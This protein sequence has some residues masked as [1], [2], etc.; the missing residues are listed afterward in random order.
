MREL[1]PNL[2]NFLI[3]GSG[4]VLSLAAGAL[5]I[6]L[7]AEL[8]LGGWLLGLVDQSQIFQRILAL[9]LIAG[10]MLALGGFLIGGGGGWVLAG[11]LGTEKRLRLLVGS[12]LTF[13]LSVSLL[14]LLFLLVT[15]F[16]ALYNNFTSD[17]VSQYALLFGLYGF[18][19]GL[20]TG[21]LLALT[22][23]H[24]RH[25]WR[26]LL[27][28]IGGF[29]LGGVVMGLLVKLVNPTAGYQAHPVLT[30]IVLLLALAA[31]LF[32][33]GGALGI[34]Y[35]WIGRRTQAAGQA[36]ETAQN[37][38]W[39]TVIVGVLGGAAVLWFISLLGSIDSFLVINPA[40]LQ[41]QL[42]VLTDGVAWSAAEN[43]SLEPGSDQLPPLGS[44]A[45]QVTG[46]DQLQY[47][48]WCSTDGVVNYQAGS[49]P[50]E[51]IALPGC[52]SAPVLAFGDRD[53]PHLVWYSR[54][55]ADTNGIIRPASL[56]VESIR[57]AEGWSDAAIVAETD[58]PDYMSLLADASG[59]LQLAWAAENQAPMAVIQE[60]YR[61]SPDDLSRLQR[62]GLETIIAGEF[63]PPGTQIPFCRNQFEEIIYTPN[64]QPVYSD[65]PITQNGGFDQLAE[66]VDQAQ[67]EFLFTT[68]QYEPDTDPP[69]PGSVLAQEIARL[70]QMVK[71]NPQDY[72]RGM[73]VRIMLGNYPEMS[74]FTWG[75]QIVDVLADLRDAGVSE[76]VN[77]EIGWRLE[78]ANFPGT[79]PHSHTK[80]V[81]VDG[82]TVAGVGFNYGYLHLPIDHPSGRGYDMLD[83]GLQI[84][85][86][87]AQLAI[88]VFDDM[89]S[90]SNQ[91]H[92]DSL[93]QQDENWLNT[94]QEKKAVADHTPEVLRTFLPAG[95]NSNAFSLYRSQAFKETDQFVVATMSA[96]QDSVDLL[97]VNF[98]LDL[99]CMANVVFPELCTLENALPYMTA[100]LQA[101]ETN[102]AR[103]R[104]IM[105]NTNSNGL[106]NRVAAR[107]FL[108]ELAKRG[109]EDQAE[110]RFYNGKLHAKGTLIDDS[111]LLIGSFNMHYSSWG[112]NG[113]TEYVLTSDD[114]QAVAEFKALYEA[115]WAEAIPFDEA[116][117][118]TSP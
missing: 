36:V 80:F 107:V 75:N 47:R 104:V 110:L 27:A 94:C 43:I 48:A 116:V 95:G 46:P 7:L 100:L 72:P 76:M 82:R 51:Q 4:F 3:G 16:I 57:T 38:R 11:L 97:H 71:A 1:N 113:L 73:T 88:S 86:P 83:L 108:D 17:P 84:S 34:T 35:G 8:D 111:L 28:S 32:F 62:I 39:Q 30:V 117:Y 29:T 118:T 14:T 65:E 109:L 54:E 85:G 18:I 87:V 114:P 92:C 25:S 60:V 20:L 68:M 10:L 79:Y 67:F 98:S 45:V 102:G 90:G 15:A 56:L 26:V 66:L 74:D 59:N 19:F 22:T 101:I 91:I 99:V 31:P 40:N 42:P 112:E 49:Q 58:Q 12:G 64:P 89:W 63:Y 13:A 5:F 96:A 2:R 23:V 44:E 41:T 70:Y 115:K 53:Q 9:P 106:E 78:V 81:V 93:S 24:L 6:Y 105:E 52:Q 61:C 103:V 21:L 69:S 77:P 55:I 50:V 37:P 33:G